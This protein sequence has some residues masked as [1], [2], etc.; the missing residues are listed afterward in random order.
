ML[1][2]Y[3]S[4]GG[5]VLQQLL[6]WVKVHFL[7][8]DQLAKE[9]LQSSEPEFGETYWSAVSIQCKIYVEKEKQ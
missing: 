6:D 9:V 7:E 2:P 4:L 1:Y 5:I 3:L 8:G